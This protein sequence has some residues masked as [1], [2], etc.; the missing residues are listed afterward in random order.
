[1]RRGRGKSGAH[2]ARSAERSHPGNLCQSERTGWED[3]GCRGFVLALARRSRGIGSG[4]PSSKSDEGPK[5]SAR[6]R[7]RGKTPK[8]ALPGS[9]IAVALLSSALA[10]QSLVQKSDNRRDFDQAREAAQTSLA[11]GIAEGG[12]SAT[13]GRDAISSPRTVTEI[14]HAARMLE[15]GATETYRLDRVI[16]KFHDA[17]AARLPH[18]E[19][20]SE[21]GAREIRGRDLRLSKRTL[22]ATLDAGSRQTERAPL[23]LH[24]RRVEA[25]F[26]R[27]AEDL[28][29]ERR[30]I[31]AS[32]PNARLAD[33]A[34][35]YR[36]AIH[37][38]EDGVRLLRTLAGHPCIE[39]AYPE[40]TAKAH[41]PAQSDQRNRR[42]TADIATPQF[43]ARQE[44]PG[45]GPDG[46]GFLPARGT[47]GVNGNSAQKIVQI[48]GAW[49][50]G[51]EDIPQLDA[52]RVLGPLKFGAWDVRTWRDHGTAAVGILSAAR[53]GFGVRGVV[54]RSQIYV[55]SVTAGG[56]NAV[57]RATK[58][59]GP[60]DV[61]SSSLVYA[62][63]LGKNGFHAPFDLP[64]DVYDA[65]R[66]AVAKGIVITCAAGNT[67]NDLSNSAIYGTRYASHATPSGAW[68]IG[69]T[70]RGARKKVSWSN[71]GDHVKF[72]AWGVSITTT[73]YGQLFRSAREA[74]RRDYTHV[75]GG[76]SA[77]SPQVAG[78]AA[79]IQSTLSQNR[80]RV[81]KVD[82]LEQLMT[83]SGTSVAGRVGPRP[84]LSAALDQL[85]I[86]GELRLPEEARRGRAATCRID[87]SN[88]EQ[89]V[90]LLST[91]K[92]RIQ[93]PFFARA[94]L[95]GLDQ[96]FA[97]VS[98][99]I[100]ANG[101]ADIVLPIPASER[102]AGA[103]IYAQSILVGTKRISG[104]ELSNAV[105]LW[106]R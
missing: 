72:S 82:E 105:E 13:E 42:K 25:L 45:A 74:E 57:S 95:I 51:H 86:R 17:W 88:G 16:V 63:T 50:L 38:R 69:A 23:A 73:A 40:F 68:I 46:I 31:R 7:T 100:S 1:M 55:S 56:G 89:F 47:I 103:S 41:V 104:M 94:I 29:A 61:F 54:P 27:S 64:Q 79:A 101:H 62:V 2:T 91:S 36:V 6:E 35:F 14:G 12:R 58:I 59:A 99:S 77:A 26:E 15:I 98:G 70:F 11:R 8:S 18:A 75:F 43:E 49:T 76:T 60:G 66:I 28:A 34:N 32:R 9:W 83:K 20:A 24:A 80:G 44:Y 102:L 19:P 4:T 37:S 85:A 97:A 10:G 106:I 21:S 30:A 33:L 71:Y 93:S 78:V 3:T 52:R 53:N 92:Q 39:T 84:N 65:V 48:E 81:L 22:E 5:R 96:I 67:G 87:A 90:L